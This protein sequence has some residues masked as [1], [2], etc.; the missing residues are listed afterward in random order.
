MDQDRTALRRHMPIL[1]LCILLVILSVLGAILLRRRHVIAAFGNSPLPSPT[2]AARRQ[3]Y[4]S[5]FT[6]T[7]IPTLP[8]P[9]L[10]SP[11]PTA[12]PAARPTPAPTATGLLGGKYAWRFTKEDRK[13]VV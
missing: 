9:Y 5:R 2:E 4:H 10:S 1:F 8:S 6:E 12:A 11:A 7:P 3:V 13:S